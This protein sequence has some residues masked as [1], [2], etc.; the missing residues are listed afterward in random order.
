MVT[1]SQRPTVVT[2][3]V[4]VPGIDVPANVRVSFT[5]VSVMAVGV[6]S[7]VTTTESAPLPKTYFMSSITPSSQMLWSL[8]PVS[9]SSVWADIKATVTVSYTTGHVMLPVT[10]DANID[11]VS[12]VLLNSSR[13]IESLGAVSLT[14]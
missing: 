5:T 4:Y 9:R 12:N 14:L 1:V 8:L 6:L 3:Y 10:I 11:N 7:H 13:M 2:V